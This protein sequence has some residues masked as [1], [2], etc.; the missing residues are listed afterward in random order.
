LRYALMLFAESGFS[1]CPGLSGIDPSLFPW[2]VSN[3]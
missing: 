3:L 1:L 2:P